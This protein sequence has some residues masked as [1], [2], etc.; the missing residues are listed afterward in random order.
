MSPIEKSEYLPTLK[1]SKQFPNKFPF[2]CHLK[3]KVIDAAGQAQVV[4]KIDITKLFY[5]VSV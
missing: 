3:E 1:K 5:P 4:S 2:I